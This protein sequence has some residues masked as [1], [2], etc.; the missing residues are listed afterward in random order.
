MTDRVVP[1]HA[2]VHRLVDAL[3]PWYVNSTL[4]AEER[5]LVTR[6]LDECAHCRGEVEWLRSLHE[7]CAECAARDGGSR[8][9]DTL[10]RRQRPARWMYRVGRAAAV[11]GVVGVAL[12]GWRAWTAD[13][14]SAA[15]RTLGSQDAVARGNVVVIF[16]PTAREADM[17]GLLESVG[18]RI[19][20]GPTATSGYV[21]A[22]PSATQ[23]RAV[24][25]LRA[26]RI[27]K[28]AEALGG[29]AVP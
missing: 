1:L 28:L 24:E 26:A 23:A 7:A 27:V 29:Q 18:A 20:Q 16:E 2:N 8:L 11:V 9:F 25:V 13:G 10:R 15:Y 14:D 3:L 12:L 21:L 19:V 5:E 6:H 22:V 17:R 4:N